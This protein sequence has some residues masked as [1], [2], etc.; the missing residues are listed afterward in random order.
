VITRAAQC[1]IRGTL[2]WSS[3]G[4]ALPAIA[5]HL[6][7]FLIGGAVVGLFAATTAAATAADQP[8][9]L[10]EIVVTAEKRASTVQDTP[11]SMTALSG[12]QLETRGISSVEA[13]AGA[14]PGVSM[15]TAGPGQTEY[16]MRGLTSSGGSVA[17]VGFYLDETP[18]SA[19]AVA[20][21]GRTVIDPELFDLN[22]VEVLR[23][24]QGT[25]YGAGSMGGTIKLV[26]NAPKLGTFEGAASVDASQTDG[27]K[28]NGGGSLML[29][30]PIG[31]R[32]ALRVVT[33]EKYIS[34]WIDR[35]VIQPGA[36]P[37]PTNFGACGYYFCTRGNVLDAPV[38]Q[39]IKD[40]NAERFASVRAALL[41]KPS[42]EL[43]V[44][45]SVMYQRIDADG[46][47]Q[48]Q[49]P[50]G[51]LAIYQPSNI[52]EPYYDSFKLA[53]LNIV[54]N[55]DGAQ[56]T[57]NTSYWQRFVIQSQDSTEPLQN[58]FNL[59]QFIPTLYQEED[60]TTQISQELRLTSTGEGPFQWVGGIFA[61]DL[62]S[63][64]VGHEQTPAFGSA[65]GCTS[66]ISGGSCPPADTFNINNGGQA[67]NPQGILYNQ[68]NPNVLKQSAVFGE[69]SYKLMP[70]LKLTGGL[71]YYK[72]N[73]HDN[74]DACGVGTGTGNGSCLIGSAA[75]S[76][77]NV[78][79]KLNLSY[80]PT[81]D[82]TLYGTASKGSRPGGVNL[83][84]PLP[85]AAQ[86]AAN[87]Y[88]YNCGPGSGPVYDTSQPSYYHPDSVWSFELGEKARF[89]D[90][91]FTLNADIYY[92]QWQNIQQ[93]IELSCGYL[94]NVNAG[95][96]HAYGPEVEFAARI[97][98]AWIL[99]LSGATT[100]ADIY[101]PSVASGIAPGT[102]IINVPKYTGTLALDYDH[103]VYTA[104]RIIGRLAESYVGPTNDIAYYRETLP[105]HSF[106]DGRIGISGNAWEAFVVG[107]NL[108]NEHAALTI[109]NTTFAWQQPTITRVST[110]Q[111]RTIGLELKYRF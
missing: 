75:G 91:R 10:V 93:L 58:I 110:N 32:A 33:T 108:T 29:N 23:G 1:L 18:L 86:L 99:N 72:F 46:Y 107:T 40:S 41:V 22:R 43:S 109:D 14:V 30:F 55:F 71:R 100:Q 47:N 17:T 35:V 45:A 95:Q 96:A 59:T 12:E 104:L 65:L 28:T 64:Y 102:R 80:T 54:Y 77:S 70:D 2:H 44:T 57:S 87:P 7:R 19:S 68:D 89:A 53:S 82:L 38:Q 98:S 76:G 85:T 27:G 48:Y 81:A 105:S 39:V 5:E 42:D 31:D 9:Q 21:N 26:S 34:G 106:L 4:G 103:P 78:L 37:Y 63:G 73:V 61:A 8:D 36:F 69:L 6:R 84:I 83:P 49:S 97:S 15:R 66:G 25:L 3:E 11:I 67:A 79:P 50:P 101:S 56:L 62:H 60:P 16:E 111:P 24:P 88:A 13:L 92:V 20:A 90:Q 51:N 94:T 74:T 52:Q